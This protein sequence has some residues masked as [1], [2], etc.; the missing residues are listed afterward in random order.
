MLLKRD[1]NTVNGKRKGIYKNANRIKKSI[2]KNT[3]ETKQ[4]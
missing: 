4:S 2:K 3:F 1:K